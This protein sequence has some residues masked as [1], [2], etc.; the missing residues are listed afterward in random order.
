[1][2]Q[3]NEEDSEDIL[4]EVF[5]KVYK[6]QKGFNPK[7]KFSSWVYRIAHNEVI[8]MHR[9]KKFQRGMINIDATDTDTR[10]LV[11][12][13]ADTLDIQDTYISEEIRLKLRTALNDLP[14]KYRNILVL[15][16]FED[17]SYIEI[18]DI[19]LKPQGTVA[20]LIKRAKSKLKKVLNHERY[21]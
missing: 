16:Y 8:D 1:M 13:L 15:R 5:L 10:A 3:N 11:S 12:L 18:G 20:V 21:R 2:T 4:Q 14:E 6:N 17:Q 9:K 7:L 19:L